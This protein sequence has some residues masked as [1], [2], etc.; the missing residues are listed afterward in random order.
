LSCNM[1]HR[2]VWGIGSLQYELYRS[3][4][5]DL[6]LFDGFPALVGVF[7]SSIP[8][9][10]AAFGFP[11]WLSSA[12]NKPNYGGKHPQTFGFIFWLSSAISNPIY[13]QAEHEYFL[14]THTGSILF[15]IIS[16]PRRPHRTGWACV[17]LCIPMQKV[18]YSS[19]YVCMALQV[20]YIL[21]PLY[22]N[23]RF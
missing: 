20:R 7:D 16:P 6:D 5:L 21:S 13:A 3:V 12:I 14:Y 15:I 9:V 19:V 8:L 11:F 2:T 4:A 23:G 1:P 10:F 22:Q 18:Y 17:L